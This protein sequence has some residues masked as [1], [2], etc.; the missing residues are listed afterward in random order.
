[1]TTAIPAATAAPNGGGSTANATDNRGR[2]QEF[3]A[4]DGAKNQAADAETDL[5]GDA[6]S[7]EFQWRFDERDRHHHAQPHENRRDRDGRCRTHG[8]QPT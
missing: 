1:M 5:Q 6:G 8:P 4:V 7:P 3:A 2:Q